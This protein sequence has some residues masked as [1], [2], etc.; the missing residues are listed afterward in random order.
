M[1]FADDATVGP[2]GD[3]GGTRQA[4]RQLHGRSSTAPSCSRPTSSRPTR[5]RS[6]PRS[7]GDGTD[8]GSPNSGSGNCS[9]VVGVVRD[10]KNHPDD[11]NT[12]HPDFDD[13]MGFS[14]TTGLVEAQLGSDEKPVYT[15]KCMAGGSF[16]D[17]IAGAQVTSATTFDQWYRYTAG[18]QQAVPR[19]PRVRPQRRNGYTFDSE[20]YFPLDGAGWGN[21]A[22]G[23]DGKMH[24]FGFT[25]ELHL[26]FTYKGGETSPRGRRRRVGLH[27]R[28]AGRRSRRS[29]LGRDRHGQHGYSRGPRLSDSISSRAE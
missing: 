5:Q 25:T 13:Y 20:E 2:F 12:G 8:A 29:P 4:T 14:P 28:Q 22:M 1:S 6:G 23:D 9:L 18:R 3:D 15:G 24:N 27:R 19:L 17:C 16:L 21:D 11:G 10:F 26:S 7:R